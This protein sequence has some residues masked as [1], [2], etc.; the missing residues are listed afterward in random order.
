M[1]L[2]NCP[3]CRAILQLAAA[4]ADQ[5]TP[6]PEDECAICWA[7]FVNPTRLVCNHFFCRKCLEKGG[8]DTRPTS[9]QWRFDD[10]Y[11]EFILYR[12]NDVA[13]YIDGTSAPLVPPHLDGFIRIHR[14][15][16]GRYDDWMNLVYGCEDT[17]WA[18]VPPNSPQAA[19]VP[20]PPAVVRGVYWHRENNFYVLR[21]YDSGNLA[22]RWVVPP[23]PPPH[24]AD[25]TPIYLCKEDEAFIG[26]NYD[27]TASHW[28]LQGPLPPAMPVRSTR[29]E[30]RPPL[31]T[32][33]VGGAG[34]PPPPPPPPYVQPRPQTRFLS[35]YSQNP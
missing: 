35:H 27:Y 8:V 31:W 13:D 32:E 3:L 2:Q 25:Y 15:G 22:K 10:R 20:P 19:P 28:Y 16:E 18:L 34:T 4:A 26:T 9:L 17:W 12:G 14:H 11:G 33:P 29:P 21:H 1:V 6:P 30:A 23:P 5:V 24:L 7:P